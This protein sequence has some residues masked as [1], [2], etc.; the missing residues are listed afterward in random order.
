MVRV[1]RVL[2]AGGYGVFGRLLAAE[3]LATTR[4]ELVVA[5]R[6]LVKAN[7][8]C[9]DLDLR[10]S[11]RIVPMRI[12]L[13]R[14]GELREAAEGCVAVVCTAGPFQAL[15][16]ELVGEAVDAGAHWVDIA[17]PIGWVLG[18]LRD[19]ELETRARTANVAVGTGL[20]TLPALSGVLARSLHERLPRA[21]EAT[22]VLSIGNRNRKG[23][24]AIASALMIGTGDRGSVETPFGPRLAYRID[25]PD[26]RLLE[27]LQMKATCWVAL[28]SPLARRVAMLARTLSVGRSSDEVTGSAR[29]L[30]R[31]SSLWGWGTPGGCVQVELRDERGGGSAAAFVGPDQRLAIL[32]AAIVVQHLVE[33]SNRPTGVIAPTEWMPTATWFS[34]LSRRGIR[35]LGRDIVEQSR[36]PR[37]GGR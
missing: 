25:A 6:D 4:A 36:V 32:P 24:A 37:P 18:I 30:S 22:V 11:G 34:E 15:P 7:A 26:E 10:S 2:I 13:E 5:G 21:R 35:A 31:A 33:G 19:T 23:P 16:T 12:D 1:P 3:L 28:E 29:L 9:H 27:D 8:A 17:D 20:S 14:R